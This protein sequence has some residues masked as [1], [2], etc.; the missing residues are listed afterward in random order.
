ML[1]P[2]CATASR[3]LLVGPTNNGKTMIVEKFR[4]QPYSCRSDRRRRW[5]R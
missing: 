4:R 1:A 3:R 2:V 5:A